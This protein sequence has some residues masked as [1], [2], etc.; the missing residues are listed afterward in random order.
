VA[1]PS[2]GQ[3][4]FVV[5]GIQN[6]GEPGAPSS[7]LGQFNLYT[8]QV[9]VECTSDADCGDGFHCTYTYEGDWFWGDD[10]TRQCAV[11]LACSGDTEDDCSFNCG[12]EESSS[13]VGMCNT[14]TLTCEAT[15]DGTTLPLWGGESDT[16]EMV[17]TPLLTST[18][19]DGTVVPAPITLGISAGSAI[20]VEFDIPLPEDY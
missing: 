18:D 8:P 11:P 14:D 13:D 5:P 4:L 12:T 9:P 19:D 7:L 2:G 16:M 3:G 6:A 17:S 1:F 10:P 15:C 20:F